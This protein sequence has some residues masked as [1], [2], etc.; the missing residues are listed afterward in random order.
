MKREMLFSGKELAI[1]NR[2]DLYLRYGEIAPFFIIFEFR[3]IAVV[4]GFYSLSGLPF[5]TYKE[6]IMIFSSYGVEL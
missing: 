5:N 4:S 2:G 1:D 3:R 6:R